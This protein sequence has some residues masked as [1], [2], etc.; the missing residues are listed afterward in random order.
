[1][2]AFWKRLGLILTLGAA[3][4]SAQ[5]TPL[6]PSHTPTVPAKAAAA[7]PAAVVARI[8]GA[9]LTERDLQR[10]MSKLFPYSGVHGGRIPGEYGAELRQ[11]A[12][13]QIVFE[14]LLHQEALRRKMAVPTATFADVM[15]QARERFPSRKEYQ[16]YAMREYGSVQGFEAQIRRA[17][18]IALLLDREITQKA[19]VTEAAVKQFYAQNQSRFRKPES[20]WIQSISLKFPPNSTPAQRTALRTRAE[21]LMAM[22]KA[23]GTFE[24]FGRLAEKFSE[25]DWRIMM[26][27]HK[28]IHRGRLPG[29]VEAVAFNLKAGQVSDILETSEAFVIVRSNGVQPQ[30]QIP[31]S[32]VS[33]SLREDLEKARLA[34][35]RRQFETYLRKTFTVEEL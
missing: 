18:L 34:D 11:Q 8:N 17:L 9:A 26:G 3:S 27:D 6:I 4:V 16:E 20:V 35:V 13:N 33:A 25:D 5:S 31:F 21:N 23:A 30:R 12:K 28:W 15:Q 24:E 7:S 19:R 2:K 29:A 14:E 10:E 22:A 1:M 32:E